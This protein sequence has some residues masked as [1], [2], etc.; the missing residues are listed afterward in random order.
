MPVRAVQ[1]V[2][3]E[4]DEQRAERAPR[5]VYVVR[6]P[7]HSL[8]LVSQS[9]CLFVYSLSFWGGPRGGGFT[10]SDFTPYGTDI[11]GEMA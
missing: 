11:G 10:R 2:G 3:Q 4:P 8:S 9:H 6:P 7:L 1:S 5:R